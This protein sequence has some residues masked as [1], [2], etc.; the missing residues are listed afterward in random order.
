MLV[1]MVGGGG[2][3]P[4]PSPLPNYWT[5]FKKSNSVY[6]VDLCVNFPN[7]V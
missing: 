6:S 5:D 3:S 4:S 2:V 1:V 7:K